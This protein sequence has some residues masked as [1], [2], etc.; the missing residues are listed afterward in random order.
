[1]V[2]PTSSLL[3]RVLPWRPRRRAINAERLRRWADP[4]LIPTGDFTGFGIGLAAWLVIIIAAPLLVIVLAWL[5]LSIELSL[6]LLVALLLLGSR[7]AGVIPWTV[8]TV[9]PSADSS[10]L[11]TTRNLVRAI[12]WIRHDNGTGTGYLDLVLKHAK[13]GSGRT[14]GMPRGAISG[15]H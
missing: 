4:N 15:D 1:M 5:L 10:Y 8:M 13:A 9:D 6:V 14:I 12:E 7:F 2:K 11:R 3:V